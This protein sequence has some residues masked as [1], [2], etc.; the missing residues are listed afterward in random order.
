MPSPNALTICRRNGR[1]GTAERHPGSAVLAFTLHE[2]IAG[3]TPRED[4]VRFVI[5]DEVTPI[6]ADH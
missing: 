2:D 4:G 6:R 3:L 1:K 5:Q